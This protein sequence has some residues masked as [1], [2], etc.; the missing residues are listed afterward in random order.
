MKGLTGL[1]K[2][3]NEKE[4]PL[5]GFPRVARGIQATVSEYHLKVCLGFVRSFSV[6]AL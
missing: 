5:H 3:W 1:V 6:L 4:S 2:H